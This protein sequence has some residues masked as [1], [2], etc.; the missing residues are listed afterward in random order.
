MHTESIQLEDN[1]VILTVIRR[2]WFPLFLQFFSVLC[3][4]LLPLASI[5][6]V[7]LIPESLRVSLTDTLSTP[8]LVG[9]YTGWLVLSFMALF[10]IWTNYYL[11]VWT[12]TSK[13]LISVDQHG[14]FNRSTGS[15]R[16]ERLQDVNVHIHGALPTLLNYGDVQAETASEDRD[17]VA[18]SV[19][20]PQGIKA[21]ILKASDDITYYTG[22]I[23][24]PPTRV[25][26]FNVNDGL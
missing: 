11:D 14:L 26:P 8:F 19:P 21:I 22:P 13:R 16:L 17:F 25:A 10:G 2:H 20:D 15:F 1:E 4:A 12:I 9:L 18:R 5:G 7:A 23:S 3:V 24:S 6:L